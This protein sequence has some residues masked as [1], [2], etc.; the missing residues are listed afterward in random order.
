MPATFHLLANPRNTTKCLPQV[1]IATVFRLGVLYSITV[2][3]NGASG[4]GGGGCDS[5]THVNLESCV[6]CIEQN[7]DMIVGVKIR[8]S[9]NATNNGKSEQ[10][11]YR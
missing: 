3:F 8:L 6:N 4:V 9:C 10:E 7:K 5:L 1:A 2:L 11:A